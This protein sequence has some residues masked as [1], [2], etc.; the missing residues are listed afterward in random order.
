MATK[1]ESFNAAAKKI[2]ARSNLRAAMMW[3]SS[4]MVSKKR[5][6]NTAGVGT[7]LGYMLLMGLAMVAYK[8][9]NTVADADNYPKI[10]QTIF[11]NKVV[12]IQDNNN[13]STGFFDRMMIDPNGTDEQW[14]DAIDA[15]QPY[16]I[17]QTFLHEE[18]IDHIYTDNGARGT[19]TLGAGLTIRSKENKQFVEDVLG[20][21]VTKAMRITVQDAKR[22]TDEWFRRFVYPK[23]RRAIN[24]PIPAR[25]FVALAVAA[26]NAGASQYTVSSNR[27]YPVVQAINSGADM[28]QV[29]DIF[30]QQFAKKRNTKWG[31][32]PN[33]YAVLA[34][35]ATDNISNETI[36]NSVAGAPYMLEQN[37]AAYQINNDM[38]GA[39]FYPG[40]LVTYQ[41]AK[42]GAGVNGYFVPDSIEEMMLAADVHISKGTPQMAIKDYMTRE[43][44][45][46]IANGGVFKRD[47]SKSG[48]AKYVEQVSHKSLEQSSAVHK[49]KIEKFKRG[50]R[51]LKQVK[52]RANVHIQH[53]QTN[54]R[55]V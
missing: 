46:V 20:R 12:D 51:N 10:T 25:A 54:N 35:F 52:S 49:R 43:E 45:R 40:R 1:R 21:K 6:S 41:N 39:G 4:K 5:A 26:Y 22:L 53:T 17:A 19:K 36:L 16:I 11:G 15:I 55:D 2:D 44:A 31:G 7:R 3:V 27:G 28:Q 24:V 18:F 47:V 50:T 14:A 9:R 29:M 34:M 48:T 30:V 13:V 38:K 8:G 37:I 42:P 33:K 23:M 32:I